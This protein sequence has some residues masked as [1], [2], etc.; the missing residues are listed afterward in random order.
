MYDVQ[1]SKNGLIRWVVSW[2]VSGITREGGC[3]RL[4]LCFVPEIQSSSHH[5]AC[6]IT[7]AGLIAIYYIYFI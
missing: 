5:Q 2:Q 3:T 6:V 7:K 4:F 1:E